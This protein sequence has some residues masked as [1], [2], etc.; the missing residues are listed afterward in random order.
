MKKAI[1][2]LSVVIVALFCFCTAQAN[3]VTVDFE[4]LP[5]LPTQPNNFAA[6]G[7]MQTYS[8]SGVFS[9]SGGV[10][11]GNPTFLTSFA[12]QGSPPNL[13]GTTDFADPSLLSTI[14][15]DLPA[16]AKTTSVSGV[17]FN[18][19][20]IPED[21]EVDY[22]SG[23]SLLASQPFLD[24]QED[25]TANGFR[26]FSFSTGLANPITRVTMTTPNADLNGWDFFVDTLVLTQNPSGT[27]PEPATM[28]LLG[29]GLIG[30]WGV[31]RKFKK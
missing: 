19:Q 7:P 10:V 15:L 18:G 25:F 11:L 30:L 12:A 5:A 9:I 26:A 13:Y 4:N 14:T 17:L 2:M 24:V 22:F 31:I 23:G 29:S 21:Y 28:L 16:A 20:T 6:A 1:S 8:Q 27:V 3:T